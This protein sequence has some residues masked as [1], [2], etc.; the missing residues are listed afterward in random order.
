[1]LQYKKICIQVGRLNLRL[2]C[3]IILICKQAI[4]CQPDP[5]LLLHGQIVG[6]YPMTVLAYMLEVVSEVMRH[7]RY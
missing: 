6:M 4:E 1:M 7:I 2:I 5:V 3:Q